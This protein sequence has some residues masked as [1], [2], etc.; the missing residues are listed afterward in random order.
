[1][2]NAGAVVDH[3]IVRVDDSDRPLCGT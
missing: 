3:R 2:L 1:V